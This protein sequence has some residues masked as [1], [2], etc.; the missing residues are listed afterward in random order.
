MARIQIQFDQRILNAEVYNTFTGNAI[1]EVLPIQ[2]IVNRWGEEIYF[3]IPIRLDL[4]KDARTEAQIGELGYWP[5]GK[6]FCI[7]FGA[8]P[9]S[10]NKEPRA[11]SPVNIFGRI[12]GDLDVLKEIK[13]SENVKVI[14][15]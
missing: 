1:I 8:T 6:A 13:Q 9:V 12:E 4:E 5:A 15:Q 3:P 7:F 10:I 14:F 2:S 11:V